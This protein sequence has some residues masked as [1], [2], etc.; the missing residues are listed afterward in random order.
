MGPRGRNDQ[1]P[2]QEGQGR[3]TPFDLLRAAMADRQDK[4]AMALFRV[5]GVLQGQT[6]VVL[7]KQS[8]GPVFVDEKT[9]QELAAEKDD[10]AVFARPA[11]G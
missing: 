5:R 2:H 11:H 10:R 1:G 6:S 9:D 8:Q 4:Q 7:V 3:E